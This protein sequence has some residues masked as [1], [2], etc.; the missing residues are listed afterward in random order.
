MYKRM[1]ITKNQTIKKGWK[2]M[3]CKNCGKLVQDGNKFCPYCGTKL[4]E[5]EDKAEKEI[6]PEVQAEEMLV[7]KMTKENTIQ[8]NVEDNEKERVEGEFAQEKS[9]QL[10]E[11]VTESSNVPKKKSHLIRNVVIAAAALCVIGYA[12]SGSQNKNKLSQEKTDIIIKLKENASLQSEYFEQWNETIYHFESKDKWNLQYSE[13][14]VAVQIVEPEIQ[15][16]FSYCFGTDDLGNDGTFAYIFKDNDI[17]IYFDVE[18]PDGHLTI[19]MYDVGTD[20]YTL[21]VD[22]EKYYISDEL[23]D[24]LDQYGLAEILTDDVDKFRDDLSSMN[25]TVQDLLK[26]DDTDIAKYLEKGK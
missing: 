19:V 14:N 1:K 17:N 13:E 25:L 16:C 12:V 26:L 2:K 18:V 4:I 8:E 11:T 7:E 22:G 23:K 21:M 15:D 10:K 20:E 5:T 3:Y 24:Y 9:E 6:S